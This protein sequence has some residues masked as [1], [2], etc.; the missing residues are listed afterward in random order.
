MKIENSGPLALVKLFQLEIDH[1]DLQLLITK[2]ILALELA[3]LEPVDD[4]PTW[5]DTSG[6]PK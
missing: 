4:D 2:V 1:L 6:I 5:I 3:S